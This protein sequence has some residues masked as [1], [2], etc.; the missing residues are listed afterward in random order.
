MKA[1]NFRFC[2]KISLRLFRGIMFLSFYAVITS[3]I[4]NRNGYTLGLLLVHGRSEAAIELM[5]IRVNNSQ[6]TISLSNRHNASN[7][8][9]V[10]FPKQNVCDAWLNIIFKDGQLDANMTCWETLAVPVLTGCF[11]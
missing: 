10:V 9:N 5:E 6:R 2:S 4:I 1:T 7:R 3:G 11:K 8:M